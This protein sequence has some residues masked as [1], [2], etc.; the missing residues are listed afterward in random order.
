[1]WM[2]SYVC[3]ASREELASLLKLQ[4]RMGYKYVGLCV[5]SGLGNKD[6]AAL[7]RSLSIKVILARVL[8]AERPG[9]AKKLL[10]E[11]E[12]AELIIGRPGSIEAYRFMSRDSRFKIIEVSPSM[13]KHI[14]RGE[15]GLLT[16]G[17][18]YLGFDLKRLINSPSNVSVLKAFFSR[19]FKWSI[20]FKLYSSATNVFEVWHPK[21]VYFLAKSMGFQGRKALEGLSPIGMVNQLYSGGRDE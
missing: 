7:A 9:E 12:G 18:G 2:D 21:H 8:C 17:G 10:R 13:I 3:P 4:R 1:L 11:G 5:E 19:V 15:A 6:I 14:D 20:P 16:I